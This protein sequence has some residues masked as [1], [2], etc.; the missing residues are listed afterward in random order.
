MFFYFVVFSTL[1]FLLSVSF[2]RIALWVT[3]NRGT[4]SPC[5]HIMWSMASC[6]KSRRQKW[7]SVFCGWFV[8]VRGT[9]CACLYTWVSVSPSVDAATADDDDV[10]QWVAAWVLLLSA[11]E[12]TRTSKPYRD[13]PFTDTK[14]TAVF[15]LMTVPRSFAM[16][17]ISTSTPVKIIFYLL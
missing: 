1:N 2:T 5:L 17:Y 8:R 12:V 11:L 14:N 15:Q 6:S 4:L 9:S 7:V 3:L 16:W 10:M 13:A